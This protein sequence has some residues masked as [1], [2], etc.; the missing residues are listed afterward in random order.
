MLTHNH[1]PDVSPD[2]YFISNM[3]KFNYGEIDC[4]DARKTNN[5]WSFNMF[6]SIFAV[7]IG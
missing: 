3:Q 7:L 4:G 6:Y 2:N 5:R 1:L